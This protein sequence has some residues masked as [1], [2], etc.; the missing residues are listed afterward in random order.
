MPARTTNRLQQRT[1]LLETAARLIA[2]DGAGALT[3]RRL[4]AEV[5][6][7]TMAIYTHFGG[8]PEL[9]RAIRHEGFAR[10]AAGLD[11]APGHDGPLAHLAML[12]LA[13]VDF[14]L[15]NTDLYRV[16]FMEQAIEDDDPEG[17][18]G[19]FATLVTAVAAC[20]FDRSEPPD[21]LALQLWSTGHGV[22][23]LRLAGL[24]DAGAVQG[25]AQGALA[26]LLGAYTANPATGI[27][28]IQA[29]ISVGGA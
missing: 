29:A 2:T 9:R 8:M 4:A 22:I 1:T 13:Y 16:M 12:C 27:D 15:A 5:G 14:G 24:L 21:A 7:S 11:R 6:T 10:L 3:L 25:I 26:A 28:A 17:A 19:T 23:A 18:A 20:D